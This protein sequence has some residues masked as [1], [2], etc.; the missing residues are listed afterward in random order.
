MKLL[1]DTQLLLWTALLDDEEIEAS[2]MSTEAARLIDDDANDLFFSVVSIWEV[3]IK[4]GLGRSTFN[5]D[6]QSLRISLLDAG[7]V[8]LGINGDHAA[9]VRRLPNLHKDPFDRMLVS[10]AWQ[11]GLILLTTDAKLKLYPGPIRRV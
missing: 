4:S 1:L 2:S 9:G 3:A 11:E 5:V 8:E 10:Q 7:L 6:P